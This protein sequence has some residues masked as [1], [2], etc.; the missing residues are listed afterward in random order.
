SSQ[1]LDVLDIVA[2]DGRPIS[3]AHW[4][5]RFG[6]RHPW[7][8]GRSPTE[9]GFL[10]SIEGPQGTALALLCVRRVS[11][12]S[13]AMLIAGGR[14]LDESFLKTL[15]LP[16]GVRAWLFRNVEPER[17]S[18][19]LIDASGPAS[20]AAQLDP[21]IARV[22]QT[23]LETA[24]TVAWPDGPETIDAIPLRDV[25]GGVLAVL[26][27]GGSGHDLAAL[28]SRIRW[29]GFGVG[30]V[31]LSVGCALAYLVAARVT[32]PVEQ[33]AD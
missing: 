10:R 19:Q 29:S 14:R 5:A 26:L 7:A 21:L 33:L 6:Y 32:R 18:H 22:R 2:D 15:T 8:I 3:S 20:G 9:T 27:L 28:L 31:A 24:E 17:S 23:G 4:P 30:A 11:V 25:N 13:H 1:G 16:P 12:G